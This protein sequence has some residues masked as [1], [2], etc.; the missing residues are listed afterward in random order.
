MDALWA[1]VPVLTC[2]GHSLAGR[3]A[4]SQL[5]GIGVPEL[6][7][8][9]LAGYERLAVALAHDPQR[10]TRIRTKI[11]INRTTTPLFDT[12]RLCREL[13]SAYATMVDIWRRGEAPRSF[14]V[15]PV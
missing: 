1:G 14:S 6:I 8:D 13:E 7:A 3:F 5:H 4:M 10:L 12:K 15:E 11:Q 9:D 2:A